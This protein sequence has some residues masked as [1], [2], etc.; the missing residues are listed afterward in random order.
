[1]PHS[2]SPPSVWVT[3][4][5][6]L[7]RAKG[8]VLD[9][10]AGGGRHTRLLLA[11][12]FSVRAIDRD[13]SALEALA[14]PACEVCECD[15]ES[16]TPAPFGSPYD[17]VVVTN[18]LY[19]PLFPLLEGALAAGGVLIYETFAL[20]NEKFALPRNPDFLLRHGELLT[21]FPALTVVAFEQGEVRRPRPSVV[22]RLAAVKGPLGRLPE[23]RLRT[24]ASPGA[25]K[26]PKRTPP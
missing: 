6:P 24:A 13:T 8:R 17:G 23:R 4:F 18:Y 12:G 25:T 1:M 16:G 10:A 22:Q 9:V 14:G 21:A 19:R 20:G 5:L 15:L 11:R 3:R 2:A 26:P 7:V